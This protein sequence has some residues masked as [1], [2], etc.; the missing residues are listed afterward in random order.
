MT[1]ALV[2][3]LMWYQTPSEIPHYA[4]ST[5]YHEL[6]GSMGFVA[7]ASGITKKQKMILAGHYAIQAKDNE[8]SSMPYCAASDAA[9]FNDLKDVLEGNKKY[10]WSI[11]G[12]YGSLR[13]FDALSAMKK[14]DYEKIMIG[15]SDRTF[16]HLFLQQQWGW[17]A[18]HA[19]MPIEMI[20]SRKNP[21]NFSLLFDM[22]KKEIGIIQYDD[23][24]PLNKQAR[25]ATSIASTLTGGNLT[26]ITKSIGTPWQ[27]DAKDKILF[28][29]DNNNKG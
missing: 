20:H 26:I 17:H 8:A 21:N 28:I 23:L 6:I 12:G 13:L 10:V 7:P 25:E 9:R 18:I 16:M 27:I 11:K 3:M 5:Q 15:Y 22:L 24:V 4:L 19:A 2:L 1:S 29:E 14:P